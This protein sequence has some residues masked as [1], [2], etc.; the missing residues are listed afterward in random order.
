MLAGP[1]FEHA[2]GFGLLLFVLICTAI[3][4]VAARDGGRAPDSRR[5]R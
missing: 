5:R 1:Y 2:V 3:Y 4:A